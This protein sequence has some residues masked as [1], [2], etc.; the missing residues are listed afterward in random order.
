MK[1]SIVVL[2]AISALFLI[3]SIPLFSENAPAAFFGIITAAILGFIGFRKYMK[4]K[5][6]I[7]E[8][9]S[10][11]AEKAARKLEYDAKHGQLRVSVAG[12]TFDNDDGSSRQRILKAV[13]Q[14]NEGSGAEGSL[15]RYEYK[16]RPA[17][18][19]LIEGRCVGNIRNDDLSDVLPILDRVEYI[20][21]Y[22]EPFDSEEGGKVYRADLVI[23]YAK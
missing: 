22:V 21:A 15:E 2:W 6:A 11:E 5:Q 13:Y 8:A 17:V 14:D 3:G 1:K 18:R 10:A 16:G 12:V 19:V 4:H 23:E 7:E 9:A 20:A